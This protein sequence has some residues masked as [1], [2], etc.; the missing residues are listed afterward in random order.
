M[1]G[2]LIN[3]KDQPLYP[4]ILW[5][6]PERR[7]QAGKLLIIGGSTNGLGS[8]SQAYQVA[9]DSQIGQTIVLLPDCLRRIAGK[10]PHIEF[11]P[12]TASGSFSLS[13]LDDL[14]HFARTCDAVLLAGDIGRSSET[15]LLFS[16]FIETYRGLLAI[17][18]DAFDLIATDSQKITKRPDTLLVLT[19]AQIRRLAIETKNHQA[20]SLDLDYT[21]LISRL[22][23]LCS[24]FDAMILT[25]QFDKFLVIGQDKV[26]STNR[27]DI[28]DTWR[29]E[30]ATR[31]MVYW[32]QNSH[33]PLEA[34]ATSCLPQR[35]LNS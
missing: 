25:R 29:V 22:H 35:L 32:L 27:A 15:A 3:Q 10:T 13:A 26:I 12:S 21:V 9:I 24:K 1:P 20:I 6:R 30:F 11:A 19:L 7:D 4:E 34:V 8:V 2:Y 31:A 17:T 28:D 33:K 5:E 18:K 14:L 16:Q 23:E